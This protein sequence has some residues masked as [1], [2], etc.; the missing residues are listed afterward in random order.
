VAGSLAWSL[1]AAVMLRRVRAA[2]GTAWS[3]TGSAIL[4]RYVQ[5]WESAD[6]DKL[7]SGATREASAGAR[8]G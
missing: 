3:S 4:A 8:S 5:T 7:V 6:L 2:W 1:V